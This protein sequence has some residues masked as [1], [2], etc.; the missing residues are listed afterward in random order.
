[1]S[2]HNTREQARAAA[3]SSAFFIDILN[4]IDTEYVKRVYPNPSKDLTKPTP[5]DHNSE[6]M[7]CTGSR[8]IVSGQ[9]TWNLNFKAQVGDFVQ[10]RSVSIYQNS[11]D[12]VIIY[13]VAPLAGQPNVFNTFVSNVITRAKAA[14][15]DTSK[16]NGMPATHQTVNF[17]SLD[18]KVARA[19]TESFW[20]QFGLYTI[21]AA[22]SQD[23]FGYYQWDPTITVAG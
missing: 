3:G 20:V 18:S 14:V 23:L 9:G 13:N 22:G 4:V 19:G 6:F 21:S 1:M 17:T 15:P 2:E 10:F 16:V 7:I 8:G 11:D 5:I 12:A